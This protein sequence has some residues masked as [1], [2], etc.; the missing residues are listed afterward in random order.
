MSW[1]NVVSKYSFKNNT[2]DT[3]GDPV[4]KNPRCNARDMVRILVGN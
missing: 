4:V 1:K 2:L 3:S